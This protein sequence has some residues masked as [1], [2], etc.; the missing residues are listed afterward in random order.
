MRPVKSYD[1]V[2]F[3]L[4]A[5]FALFFALEAPGLFMPS[6]GGKVFSAVLGFFCLTFCFLMAR[7]GLVIDRNG[8]TE[9]NGFRPR[10]TGWQD[11]EEVAIRDGRR[12]N[13]T[14]FWLIVLRL[15][16][17]RELSVRSTVGQDRKKVEAVGRRILA[18]RTAAVGRRGATGPATLAVLAGNPDQMDGKPLQEPVVG[19]DGVPV[20]VRLR[21]PNGV[22]LNWSATILPDGILVG[23][24]AAVLL[25][26]GTVVAVIVRRI[27]KRPGYRLTVE[28][29]G[30]EPRSLTL[31]FH[32][33]SRAVRH[34][35]ELVAAVGERGAAAVPRAAMAG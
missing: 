23:L 31:A 5:A 33:R 29:G 18:M 4:V 30:P 9:R 1:P 21:G 24:V 12:S 3:L 10:R 34:V 17:G 22:H 8:L 26:V 2:R 28:V 20:T 15:R 11:V 19:P 13:G 25:A 16:D 6:I 7:L 27:R 32:S 14:D 35:R